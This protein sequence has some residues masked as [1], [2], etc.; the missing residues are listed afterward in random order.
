MWTRKYLE[1]LS[2]RSI[3]QILKFLETKQSLG[4]LWF[5]PCFFTESLHMVNGTVLED[6]KQRDRE[7]R[8]SIYAWG[9]HCCKVSHGHHTADI[10]FSTALLFAAVLQRWTFARY[11][12]I[13][14]SIIN[15]ERM[16]PEEDKSEQQSWAITDSSSHIWRG[17]FHNVYHRWISLPGLL[18]SRCLKK[19]VNNLFKQL[20]FYY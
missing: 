11:P 3:F 12:K 15:G 5:F 2:S 7:M 4:H 10:L 19:N 14:V 17:I 13:S 9:R 1:T 18:S 6:K 20:F 16:V 8:C